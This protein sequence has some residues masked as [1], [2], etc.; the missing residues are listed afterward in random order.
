MLVLCCACRCLPACRDGHHAVQ[1]GALG[2]GYSVWEQGW[3]CSAV[4]GAGTQMWYLQGGGSSGMLRS[5]THGV[6]TGGGGLVLRYPKSLEQAAGAAQPEADN[7]L[8]RI[9]HRKSR[10]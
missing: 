3:G 7:W 8:W 2:L 5:G 1:G 9:A 4:G 6:S 10:Q